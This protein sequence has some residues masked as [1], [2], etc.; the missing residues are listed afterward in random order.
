M[1]LDCFLATEPS[2]FSVVWSGAVVWIRSGGD[3]LPLDAFTCFFVLDRGNGRKEKGRKAVVLRV[4][5]IRLEQPGNG[6]EEDHR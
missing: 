3:V 2:W 4:E 1:G 6:K 5:S